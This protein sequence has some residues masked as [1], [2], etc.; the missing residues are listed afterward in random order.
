MGRQLLAE[1][2]PLGY[3]GSLTHL[4]RLLNGWR[5]A[6]FAAVLSASVPQCPVLPD[7]AAIVPC[8]RSSRRHCASNRTGC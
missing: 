6:H 5:R 1:I 8:H 4:Q 7:G 2:R 3:T